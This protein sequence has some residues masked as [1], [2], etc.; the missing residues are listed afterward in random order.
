M[1]VMLLKFGILSGHS[2]CN[3]RNNINQPHS[4]RLQGYRPRFYAL[5]RLI[6][7]PTPDSTVSLEGREAHPCFLICDLPPVSD[8]PID[9]TLHFSPLLV[10][11]SDPIFSEVLKFLLV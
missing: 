11:E 10:Q 3:I 2:L 8:L 5:T 4:P 6:S 7:A 1:T 9:S